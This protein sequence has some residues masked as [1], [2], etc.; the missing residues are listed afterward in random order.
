MGSFLA[1]QILKEFRGRAV[2]TALCDHHEENRTRL[3]KRL[4][5]R[6]PAKNLEETLEASDLILEAA[7]QDAAC[8]L[9]LHPSAGSKTF[10]IMSVGGILKALEQ[11]PDLL[12]CFRGRIIVP[13]GAVAGIDGLLAAR[14]AG[15]RSVTLKTR[16]PPEALREA[17][18]FRSRKFPPLAG[19]R[20]VCLFRGA[21]ARAVKAF[22]QNINVAA[23][24]SLAGLGSLKTR[25]EIWTS[26]SFRGNQH[27][28]FIRHKRGTLRVTADNEPSPENK[29]TS[30]LAIFAALAALRKSFDALKIGT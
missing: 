7:S 12:S 13:S 10:L 4:K 14:E 18:F 8:R 17:P 3:L 26:K 5:L 24:L 11:K 20:E 15:L 21:A 2:L 23:V 27:E 16:K 19:S 30:A 1:K 29:K 22:P 25:V 6:V 28:I 9:L